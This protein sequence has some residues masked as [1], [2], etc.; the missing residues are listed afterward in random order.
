[1]MQP[2]EDETDLSMLCRRR[3]PRI[4][5][6]IEVKLQCES[7]CVLSMIRDASI[8]VTAPEAPIGVGL[9]HGE[10]LPLGVPIH[11]EVLSDSDELPR[12]STLILMWTRNFD[13]DGFLSGGRLE[14]HCP[15]A[16]T[17][18]EDTP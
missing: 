5:M 16:E 3:V 18:P 12:E 13:A 11:C 15:A 10:V 1:M 14:H 9:Y 2:H 17:P 8:D 6:P 4:V 7:R